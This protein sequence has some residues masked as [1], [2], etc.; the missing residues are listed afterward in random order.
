MNTSWSLDNLYLLSPTQLVTRILSRLR[1]SRIEA[2]TVAEIMAAYGLEAQGRPEN[3]A[4]SRRNRSVVVRT[5]GGKKVLKLYRADWAAETIAFE[6]SVLGELQTLGLPGPRLLRTADGATSVNYDG[7]YYSIFEFIDGISYCGVILP[8]PRH[9]KLMSTAGRLL[10][11]MHRQ[12]LHFEPSGRHHHGFAARDA[13]R[14]RSLAWELRRLDDLRKQSYPL[15]HRAAKWMVATAPALMMA[16]RRS[17]DA[18][19]EASLPRT[20]IHGDYGLHNLLFKNDENAIPVDFELARLEWRL[21]DLVSCLSRFRIRTGAY[22]LDRMGTFL[23]AYGAEFPIPDEEWRWFPEVWSYYKLTNAVQYWSA[24][25]VA[26]GLVKKLA[27]AREAVEQADWLKA[28][29]NV[30]NYLRRRM[31]GG[32][33]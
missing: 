4:N 17:A 25:F 6:H 18:L 10:A 28:N 14:A 7:S 23:E 33:Q 32:H 5:P 30:L 21:S 22:D 13:D 20:I 12:L 26:N 8:R 1:S 3:L 31:R 9:L 29:P 15:A 2:Q 16:L 19:E 27:L 24:Y 11:R